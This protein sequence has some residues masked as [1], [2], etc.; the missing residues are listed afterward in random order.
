MDAQEVK[1]EEALEMYSR[2]AEE[3]NSLLP[4][5]VPYEVVLALRVSALLVPLHRGL[6]GFKLNGGLG[7]PRARPE[8]QCCARRPGS[9]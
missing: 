6:D 3:F 5:L 9:A 2:A 4:G 8:S 1:I 7:G